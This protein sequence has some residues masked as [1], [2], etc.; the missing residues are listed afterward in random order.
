M[1]YCV[2]SLED[3]QDNYL[4]NEEKRQ[5]YSYLFFIIIYYF[6]IMLFHKSI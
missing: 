4:E 3:N 1:P 5:L 2:Y 6:Q